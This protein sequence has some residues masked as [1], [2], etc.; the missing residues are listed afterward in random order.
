MTGEQTEEHVLI[1]G[2]GVAGVTTA[3]TLR[4]GGYAGKITIVDSGEILHDRPP[5][6]KEFLANPADLRALQLLPDETAA[7]LQIEVRTRTEATSLDLRTLTVTLS[8]GSELD[9][10]WIVIA[11]GGLAAVPVAFEVDSERVHVIR[12]LMDAQRLSERL[13]DRSKIAIMGAGLVGA[14]LAS[15]L[16][17]LNHE[18]W[19]IDPEPMPLASNVGERLAVWLHAQHSQNGVT[20]IEAAVKEIARRSEGAAVRLDNDSEIDVDLVVIAVG[21]EPNTALASRSGL[22]VDRAIRVSA[23]QQTSAE[24]V[25]AVGDASLAAGA[26]IGHWDAA[27]ESGE[28]AAATIL[29][30]DLPA[31][32]APWFWSDRGDLHLDVVG[33]LAD[34][35]EVVVRGNFGEPP[36]SMFGLS[37]SRLVAFVGIDEARLVRPVRRAIDAGL[38]VEAAALTDPATN[39]RK[40]LKP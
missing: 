28:R 9:A 40:L 20:V 37:G 5:L 39:L 17:G 26:L 14:E 12:E 32:S 22:D 18:V 33:R 19:L 21:M 23:T 15:T 24:R 34:A 4:R 3:T 11:T 38:A 31:P 2:G 8:D 25:L 1:I 10:D 16:S 30:R 36:F 27:K 7:E 6:T 35:D 29:G 13:H